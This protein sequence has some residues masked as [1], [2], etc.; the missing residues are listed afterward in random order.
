MVERQ[1]FKLPINGPGSVHFPYLYFLLLLLLP[2]SP[3]GPSPTIETL[4][5]SSSGDS[6]LTPNEVADE[7]TTISASIPDLASSAFTSAISTM[8]SMIAAS[9]ASSLPSFDEGLDP[10]MLGDDS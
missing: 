2:P 6:Q 4:F 1:H 8:S 7:L 5:H 3:Q 9:A 10:E